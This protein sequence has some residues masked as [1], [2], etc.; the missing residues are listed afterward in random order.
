MIKFKEL[1]TYNKIASIIISFGFVFAIL[2]SGLFFFINNSNKENFSAGQN[3]F[4]NEISS[5]LMLKS[6]P[7]VNTISDLSYW[8]VFVTYFSNPNEHDFYEN[9][10]STIESYDI[11]FIGAYALDGTLLNS[12]SSEG[13]DINSV[14]LPSP[15]FEELFSKRY[16][17]F[18]NKSEYGII[19][20]H[21]ATV[22]PTSN[23]NKIK[24]IP[25]GFLVMMR[26]LDQNYYDN[27]FSISN[28]RM[29]NPSSKVDAF[30]SKLVQ[31]KDFNNNVI[32]EVLLLGPSYFNYK[33]TY[34]I[35]YILLFVFILYVAI[36]LNIANRWIKAPLNL[37]QSVLK[38]NDQKALQKLEKSSIDFIEIAQLFK[39]AEKREEDL[40]IAKI[41][42]EES[43]NLKTSFLANLSHEIRTPMNAILGFS[44]LL[45]HD[46]VSKKEKKEYL[47]I[48]KRS[49][50][51]LISIID[52]LI[53]MSK[54]DGKQIV[55]NKVSFRIDNLIS[56]IVQ[57]HQVTIPKTKPVRLNLVL[58]LNSIHSNIISDDVKIK[59]ILTNL[60]SNALKFT[61]EGSVSVTYEINEQANEIVFA[62]K[63]TGKGIDIAEQNVIFER[64]RQVDNNYTVESGGLGLGLAISRAYVELMGGSIKV[65][66][67]LGVGTTFSFSIPLSLDLEAKEVCEI[68]DKN[69]SNYNPI[70]IDPSKKLILV[71][72]D[73][74]I[75]FMLIKKLLKDIG[76]KII[77]AVNGVEA[78]EICKNNSEIDLIIMDIKMPLKDGFEARR[79]ITS[80]AP[81]LPM[82]AHTAF[83]AQEDKKRTK[84]AGFE[85]HIA[86]PLNKDILLTEI[87]QALYKK[88]PS[89]LKHFG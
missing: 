64:F 5:L 85:G 45:E 70:L 25:S 83:A 36:Y 37:I 7:L 53:E 6:E 39:I 47:K 10:G 44:E 58:P 31:Y 11:D 14:Q 81:D 79:E 4:D 75:N 41:K 2:F 86:K 22:H 71:A 77:R 35:L 61:A 52:D 34:K 54:I 80:F 51:N 13:F 67:Q 62:V 48:I 82:L 8:D 69:N 49:G 78:V 29:S 12:N 20:I 89:T 74:N 59:Q 68:T 63:D 40:K 55:P 60:I 33:N 43:D 9:V 15:L 17:K 56:D 24:T 65:E 46:K 23:I 3:A 1:T 16:L 26:V 57:I 19:E 50:S 30:F 18:Y 72:E 76:F 28:A 27:I 84:E 21:G 88:T 42:A 87:Q 66:S 38:T 73:D 32:D